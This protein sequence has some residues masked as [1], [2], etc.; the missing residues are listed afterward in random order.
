[1]NVHKRLNN[2]AI[3]TGC[4]IIFTSNVL[5]CNNLNINNN[6]APNIR[7][8]LG[9][10]KPRLKSSFSKFTDKGVK[11]TISK[12]NLSKENKDKRI[13]ATANGKSNI[14]YISW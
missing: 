8:S 6:I 11:K 1:M 14:Q 3:V 4:L 5:L 2:I 12:R 7:G 10:D 13:R 9:R